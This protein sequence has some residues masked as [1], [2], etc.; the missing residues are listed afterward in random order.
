MRTLYFPMEREALV[1]CG[2][3]D[4]EAE[5]YLALLRLGEPSVVVLAKETGRHR[6]HIYDTLE[7][8]CEKGLV[9]AVQIGNK[10]VFRA[11]DPENLLNVLKEQEEKVTA[12]LPVLKGLYTLQKQPFNLM[13]FKGKN[14]LKSLLRDILR[15]GKDYDAFGTG[16]RFKELFP[17]FYEQWRKSSAN[18]GMKVRLITRKGWHVPKRK[19]FH[20]KVF[21]EEFVSPFA[22]FIYGDKV[23]TVIWS[24]PAAILIESKEVAEDY[25]K[26]FSFLW[27]RARPD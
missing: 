18:S 7:K 23:A 25:R 8:L 24:A 6:T 14:G 20:H 2:L 21:P 3:S 17:F 26:Y 19:G 15:E 27:E 9:S 4:G 22:V 13:V 5:V 12:C 11:A 16:S 10:Q 1:A